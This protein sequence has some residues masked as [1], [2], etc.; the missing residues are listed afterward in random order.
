MLIQVTTAYYHES[1]RI[2]QFAE[3]RLIADANMEVRTSS[4]Y[5]HYKQWCTNNGCY[6]DNSRNFNQELRKF[7]NVVRRRPQT[8]GEKTTLLL[9]YRLKDVEEE[10]Q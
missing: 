6:A 3:D 7:G 4:V 2:A 9:G 5:G 1:D 8:G 10:F